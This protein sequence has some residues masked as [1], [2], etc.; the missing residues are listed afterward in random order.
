MYGAEGISKEGLREEFS[1]KYED[2]YK[3]RLF[4]EEGFTRKKCR[5]CGK[6]FWSI[7]DRDTCDEPDHTQY[8]FF[9]D[10]PKSMSYTEL[11]KRFAGFFEKNGHTAIGR[12]P[13][14]SRWR[15]DLYFTIASIQDFQRIENGAMGFEYGANPLVVPQICLR[16]SDIENVGVTGRHFTGFMMAGQHAFNWPKEGYWKDDTIDL[17]YRFLT[18]VLGVKKEDLVY[19]EDAWAM[20]DFS[21]FGPCLESFSNGLE[22]VNS[23]FTQFGVG[24]GGRKE[25]DGKVVDV[26]WGFER[27]LWFYTGLDNA[28]EA[29]FPDLIKKIEQESGMEIDR[30]LFK[31]FSSVASELDISEKGDYKAKLAEAMRKSGITA[32][33]YSRKVRPLQAV[34]AILDHVRTLLFAVSDGAMPSN[35]GG[36]YNLRIILRRSLGFV[37]EYG[38]GLDL[39]DIARQEAEELKD[40]YPELRDSLDTFAKIVGIEKERYAKSRENAGRMVDGIISKK[41]EM[42][43]SELRTLYESHGITPELISSVAEAK[44]VSIRMPD[45]TYEDI[46]KGDFTGREK[47]KG[48]GLSIP[49]GMEPTKKLYY[50]YATAS[51]SAVLHARGNQIILDITPFYPDGGG[52]AA[53]HGTINGLGV[54]DVQKAGDVIVHIMDGDVKDRVVEGSV[55][56]CLVD[57]ER[58]ERLMVHHT[59]T[60]MMSAAARSV[61]GK[62]AWQEGTR[63]EA[64]KAHIDIVHYDRLNDGDVS[65]LERFVNSRAFNGIRVRVEDME[66]G[67]AENRFGFS[68]YQGH[69]VPSKIMRIVIIEDRDGNLIDAE[70][71]GGLHVAGRE[72]LIGMI[73]I[74]NASRIHDGVNRIEFVAG[75]AALDYFDREHSELKTI[76]AGMNSERFETADKVY[77]LKEDYR[78]AAKSAEQASAALALEMCQKVRDSASAEVVLQPMSVGIDVLRKVVNRL[79][80]ENEGKAVLAT[81]ASGNFVCVSGKASGVNAL[82]F[83][84]RALSSRGFTGGGSARA[85]EGR[86][87]G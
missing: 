6:N 19:M 7:T 53:D 87:K 1:R 44:G 11:W 82:E 37:E 20:G 59:S 55:A 84:Q 74:V 41:R 78:N 24:A 69:G 32:E 85:A 49:E 33:E 66:R 25:L 64:D 60:H 68:I 72:S 40:L 47:E 83:A 14:V 63:K 2:Y 16:F 15:Q 4:D 51:R 35:I 23:V 73:K 46:I 3:V 54:V 58:R 86:T 65:A 62:H 5:L 38:L 22:L 26:G 52:Q 71:C 17:N 28:Y 45:S 12:Y 8:S 13:V 48:A 79:V 30:K 31:R 75:N 56:E 77:K 67:E 57:K 21:E 43:K 39:A 70:A 9:K 29:V 80:D 36:G 10:S 18:G 50:E 81:S 42:S 27:L 34:Y 76:A 61:L